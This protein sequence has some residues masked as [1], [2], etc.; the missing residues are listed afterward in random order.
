LICHIANNHFGPVSLEAAQQ[1]LGWARYLESHAVR[2]YASLSLDNAEAAR[3]IW[4]KVRKGD[5][6]QPFTARDIQ[7]RGWS[8]LTD[9]A[10]IQAGLQALE[11]A[12]RLRAVK[13]DTG[14]RPS[15]IFHINPKAMKA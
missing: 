12:N 9:S 7:Q 3:A 4:A 15:T 2:A 13:V 11:E 6:P 8:G 10:R 5:L 1:A 14:G